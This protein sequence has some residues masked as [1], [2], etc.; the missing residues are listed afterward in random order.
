MAPRTFVLLLLV[1]FPFEVF[2]EDACVQ[3]Q[4][5]DGTWGSSYRVSTEVMG[6]ER[7]NDELTTYRF[8]PFKNYIVVRWP[9]LGYSLFEVPGYLSDLPYTYRTVKDQRGRPYRVK[10]APHHGRCSR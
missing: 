3:Y 4:R 6:G 5:Q 2:A 7:L 9:N 1:F 8:N 10:A